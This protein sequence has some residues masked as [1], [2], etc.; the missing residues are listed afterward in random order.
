MHGKAYLSDRQAQ[1][2]IWAIEEYLGDE[3]FT[4]DVLPKDRRKLNAVKRELESVRAQIL[5]KQI[6]A[7]VR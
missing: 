2:A 5:E 4:G 1:L 7:G 3:Q 6:K